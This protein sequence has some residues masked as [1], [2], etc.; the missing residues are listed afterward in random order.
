MRT[1]NRRHR[2]IDRATDVLSFPLLQ[3]GEAL[4]AHGP[5]L[6]GDLILCLPVARAQ[7]RRHGH[8]LDRELAVLLVHGMLHLL[9]HDHLQP[10]PARAMAELE[11][12]VLAAIGVPPELALVGRAL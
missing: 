7:A 10:A 3:P 1:L 2:G 9:G 4:P 8:S 6:L 5:V 12:C 11:M